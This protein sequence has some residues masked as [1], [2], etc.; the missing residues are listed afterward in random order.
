[1]NLIKTV[2]L[3][4]VL[5]AFLAG[6]G[7]SD[8][9]KTKEGLA[10]KIFSDGKGASLKAGQF[11]K[12]YIKNT[13]NDSTLMDNFGHLPA[14]G[15]YD[16]ANKAT[17]NFTDFL[18]EMK[19]GDSAIFTM[20]VDTLAKKGLLQYNEVF[21][22]GGVFKGTVKLVNAFAA[23]AMVNDDYKAEVEKEKAREIAGL[24]EYLK[25]K[26][27]TNATKT[28]NGV[29]VV[30]DKE[31]TGA[32]ADSNTQ[33]KVNYTGYLKNG[34]KFDSNVDTSFKHTE[35][36]QFVV[37]THSVIPGWDEGIKKFKAGS[38]GRLFVPAMMAYGQQSQGEKMP[39]YSDL[40]FDMEVIE[41]APAPAAAA[42][43][44]LPPGM[45][46]QGR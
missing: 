43:P 16:T 18:G 13:V 45:Q 22:K 41:V 17:Y 44:Q 46:P 6:C 23:E 10:Y 2:G 32:V 9:K 39:A 19:V 37:G 1:M 33:V 35:P 28:E 8:Y 3:P 11:V 5:G 40:I 20:S 29:F 15:P 7:N 21:K 25:S 30:I 26:N 38:K 12:V 4:V 42:G 36:Y 27:I 14:Y 24:E 31:G 34:K